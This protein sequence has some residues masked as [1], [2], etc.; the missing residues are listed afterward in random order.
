VVTKGSSQSSLLG[1]WG[2]CKTEWQELERTYQW[3][4]SRFSNGDGVRT[5]IEVAYAGTDLAY[6]VGYEQPARRSRLI[7][8]LRIVALTW[9]AEPVRT[10]ERSSS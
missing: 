1:A 2:P 4:G 8:M 5:D 9:G 7:A 6:I 3:V 10:W